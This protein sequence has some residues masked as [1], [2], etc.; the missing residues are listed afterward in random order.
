M[1]ALIPFLL[2]LREK[3][4]RVARR[5]R[6]LPNA[7]SA[8]GSAI[9]LTRQPSAATLSLKGRGKIQNKDKTSVRH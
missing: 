8:S 7:S 4:D 9:P 3:V 6:G 1:I 2:P 5:M